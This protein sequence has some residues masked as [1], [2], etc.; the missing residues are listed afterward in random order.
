MVGFSVNFSYLLLCSYFQ[1]FR[2]VLFFNPIPTK[3][4]FQGVLPKIGLFYLINLICRTSNRAFFN[5]TTLNF[6]KAAEQSIPTILVF[7]QFYNLFRTVLQ[8]FF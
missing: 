8:R 2:E 4:E 1:R 7:K 6:W 5:S 3:F